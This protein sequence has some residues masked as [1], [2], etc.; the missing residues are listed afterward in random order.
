MTVPNI[1]KDFVEV[2]ETR[3]PGGKWIAKLLVG[4]VVLALIGGLLYLIL[5]AGRAVLANFPTSFPVNLEAKDW[6]SLAV[7]VLLFAAF[8]FLTQRRLK[9]IENLKPVDQDVRDALTHVADDH[10]ELRKTVEAMDGRVKYVEKKVGDEMTDFLMAELMKRADDKYIQMPPLVEGTTEANIRVELGKK[11]LREAAAEAREAVDGKLDLS[12]QALAKRGW[13]HLALRR[14]A[15]EILSDD[16]LNDFRGMEKSREE[17]MEQ[18]GQSPDGK[19]HFI[20]MAD[21][22]EE[23][24]EYLSLDDLDPDADLPGSFEQFKKSQG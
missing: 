12:A 8:F 5:N 4:L 23:L 9:K 17:K 6:V 16:A 18:R 3:L 13:L 2:V 24:A 20:K 15:R 14:F 10:L 7:V 1:T 19:S 11:I 21:H 22:F